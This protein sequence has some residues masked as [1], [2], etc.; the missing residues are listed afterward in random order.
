MGVFPE[1]HQYD[2]LGL[3]ELVRKKDVTPLE[4]VE[5]AISRIEAYNPKINAVI[6]KMYAKARERA[7]GK[8]PEG[9]FT[10]VPFL[11][12]DAMDTLEGEPTSSGTRIMRN[13]PQPHDS[14]TV[15]RF[16]A[17]GLIFLGKTNLSELCLL[18]YTEPQAFGPTRNPWD[19]T[20]TP[21]GSSGGSAAAVAACM[22]PVAGG[23]DGGGSIRIPASCCG[24]FGLK[25]TRGR[26]PTGPDLG[27]PWRGLAQENVISRS[28]R[29]SAAMLD[30]I[31]GPD[32]G[33]PY[34]APPVERPY[35]EE[36]TTEPGRLRI[37]FTS[38]PFMGKDVHEDCIK[39]LNHT[40]Q[41]LEQL[42]HE[43]V[44]AAPEVDREAFSLS[45][46]TV[47]AAET[48]AQV[49][50]I[51]KLVGQ[52]PSVLDFE[53]G[54]QALAALGK[55]ISAGDYAKALN[56][57][58]ASSRQIARFFEAYDI[59]ITPTLAQ[60]PVPIGSLQMSKTESRIVRLQSRLNAAW[61]MK[62]LHVIDI[63]AKKTFD[64]MPYTAVFNV[65][66]QPAMSVPLHWNEEMLPVGMQFAAGF[67]AEGTLFRLAGQLERAQPWF[68]KLPPGLPY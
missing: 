50:S 32:V 9:S 34:W 48:C 11:I 18:P 49:S 7:K 42:G 19:L 52:K 36:V 14:E 45:Y 64:F 8:L 10:G 4:L 65:T 58:S 67:G 40:A 20:R 35:R 5:E 27:D 47:I 53:P 61:I 25:P 31:A 16:R 37:A 54:T 21:G 44:E 41:L 3:A 55:V 39:G 59:L 38:H 12:K 15:R 56:Y 43:V 62:A 17:A 24:V 29:D 60:S 33:A 66:G 2:G 26:V 63:L 23:N 28:V 30:A 22:V 57:L 13:V 1:F 46:L 6:H 51:I 68:D